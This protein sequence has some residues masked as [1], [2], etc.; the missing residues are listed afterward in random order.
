M[1]DAERRFAVAH[2]AL[3]TIAVTG[4]NGKTTTTSMIHE[5][6]A[7][8]GEPSAYLTTLG[9]WVERQ[10]IIN[11]D[12]ALEFLATVERAVD[13][14]ARTLALEVTSK[15]LAL[16]L[17]GRWAAH[18]AV[19]TN[20]S[21]DHLDMHGTPEQYL[22]AK[23]QLFLALPAGGVAVLNADDPSSALIAELLPGELDIRWF[24]L[25]DSSA[26]LAATN[27]EVSQ[28]GTS[29]S[30]ADSALAR[31][32]GGRLQL[33]IV[34]RVHAQ[35]ALASALACDAAGY[36]PQA[37]VSGL[38][39]FEGVTGRFQIVGQRPLVVVDY[40]HTP[41]GLRSTLVTAR[42][43]VGKQG[44]LICVFGCGG[45][46][47]KGKRPDMGAAVHRLADVAVLTTDNPRSESPKAIAEGV[48]QGAH[49][50]GA[51]WIERLDRRD[52][53]ETTI[54]QAMAPDVVVIA[55][56]GH[57]ADQEIAGQLFPFSDVDIARRACQTRT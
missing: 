25:F 8:S 41:D 13:R 55:G 57:E 26:T 3:R 5:I 7:S 21:R 22:A 12:P 51:E 47:D 1:P 31:R 35:N 6:V 17:A 32:L 24:S 18:V 56:K 4:T 38:S 43:L 10:K 27:V 16:G 9:A 52:A 50:Q 36:S 40:A 30:L 19:F 49:G 15:A 28:S 34:G 11:D 44:R 20:L 45:D 37:I 33:K 48:R 2:E 54:A 29:V 14:G 46:R 42:D 23:A 53:I 39:A